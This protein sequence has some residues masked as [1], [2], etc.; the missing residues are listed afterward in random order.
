MIT[1]SFSTC[2]FSPNGYT[3]WTIK[4]NTTEQVTEEIPP[5]STELEADVHM[6]PPKHR[7]VEINADPIALGQALAGMEQAAHLWKEM[8]KLNS[9]ITFVITIGIVDTVV[10]ILLLIGLFFAA[11]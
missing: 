2:L 6:P 7:L 11:A 4:M 5:S 9:R 1:G 10:T 8:R 3:T